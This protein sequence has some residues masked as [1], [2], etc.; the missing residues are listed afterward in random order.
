MRERRGI[1]RAWVGK[2]ERKRSLER[3]RQRWEDNIRIDFQEVGCGS[4]DWI[5]L[6]QDRGRCRSLVNKAISH[7][8]S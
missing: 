2:S 6:A 7:R 3:P 1:Y 5:D 4:I 8:V